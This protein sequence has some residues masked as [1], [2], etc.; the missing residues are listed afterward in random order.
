MVCHHLDKKVPEDVAFAESRIRCSSLLTKSKKFS[1]CVLEGFFCSWGKMRFLHDRVSSAAT[2]FNAYCIYI[3]GVHSTIDYYTNCYSTHSISLINWNLSPNKVKPYV[4][5]ISIIEP[6]NHSHRLLRTGTKWSTQ[7]CERVRS[8]THHPL[9]LVALL[10]FVLCR[11]PRE[12]A[13]R[14]P[15]RTSCT[16][17][18]PLAPCPPTLR[19]WA[20]SGRSSPGPG[21]PPTR[22][23]RD[24]LGLLPPYEE[25]IV[26][27]SIYFLV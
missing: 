13:R 9:F 10:S 3:V 20:G 7:G 11:L 25:H 5:S 12:G 19:P 14:S 18:V 26:A 1:F 6:S 15:R 24:R 21:R 27:V 8:L 22:C 4:P 16:T 23:G 2:N 17:W